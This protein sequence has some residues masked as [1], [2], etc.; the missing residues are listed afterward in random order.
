MNT[1][2]FDRLD[3]TTW[4]PSYTESTETIIRAIAEKVGGDAVDAVD[5]IN[6][7]LEA[8]GWQWID[9]TVIA[10][11]TGQYHPLASCHTWLD[12]ITAA[13]RLYQQFRAMGWLT[14]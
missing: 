8:A 14:S 2:Q 10:D 3:W 4:E 13:F 11:Q 7:L 5:A 6:G 12:T 9:T 1:A